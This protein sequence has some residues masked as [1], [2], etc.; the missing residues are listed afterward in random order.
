MGFD[1]Q[2]LPVRW[3]PKRTL[4]VPD[5]FKPLLPPHQGPIT[6]LLDADSQVQYAAIDPPPA[7]NGS[8]AGKLQVVGSNSV[9]TYV[10]GT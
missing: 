8:S 2:T 1:T 9:P 5:G 6:K 10:K 4:P 7:K 3:S